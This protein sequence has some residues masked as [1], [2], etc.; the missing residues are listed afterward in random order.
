MVIPVNN[1]EIT[2]FLTFH[3]RETA[4]R[5][6]TA[7]GGFIFLTHFHAFRAFCISQMINSKPQQ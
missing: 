7:H 5:R 6:Q 4:E 3:N 1:R 2:G